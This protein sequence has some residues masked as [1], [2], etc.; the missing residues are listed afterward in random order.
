MQSLLESCAIAFSMYSRIPVPQVP[1][2]EDNMKYTVCFFPLVGLVTGLISWIWTVLAGAAGLNMSLRAAVLTVI[3]VLVTGGIHLDGLLDTADAEASH[4]DRDRK[5]EIMHDSQSGAFAIICC[6]VYLL[7]SFGIFSQLSDRRMLQLLLVY[8]ISRC[9]SGYAMVKFRMAREDGLLYSFAEAALND[10]SSIILLV[11]G[12]AA[13]LIL[14]ISAPGAGLLAL[15]L[16][17]L[18]FAYYRIRSYKVY[19]GITGDLAGAFLCIC[20][21]AMTFALALAG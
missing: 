4:L 19:D 8:V 9:L 14:L 6:G 1:W 7:L 5:L 15:L 16:A 18:C 13:S 20:E 21:L 3:P 10:R 11:E 12:A 17:G 2:N